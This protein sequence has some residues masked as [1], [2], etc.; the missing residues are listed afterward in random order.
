M[1]ELSVKVLGLIEEG[2]TINSICG[3]LNLSHKQL[4]NILRGL[5]MLGIEFNKKYYY[6]GETIYVPKKDLSWDTKKNTVNIIT[7]HD[8]NEFQ[9]MVISD[10]HVGN[11]LEAVDAWNKIYEYCIIN[12]IHIIIIAGDFLDG[13]NVGKHDH[14]KH[15]NSLEQIRYAVNNYPFDKN[16]INVVTLGNHDIDSLTS[17]GIDFSIYLRNFRP[18]IV[19]VGYGH[20]RIN[21]KNDRIFITHPLGINSNN[22][23]ELPSNYLLIKGHHHT[24]KSCISTNGN[25]S[26]TAPTLSNLFTSQD[27][28]L[29]GAIVLSIKFK[30][31][32]FDVVN[33]ENLMVN[34]RVN[35]VGET[36]F[37]ITPSKDRKYDGNIKHEEDFSKRK[38]LRKENK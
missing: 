10:L 13:I 2:F 23:F 34:D 32:F 6:D 17:Y 29:P 15:S 3:I 33:I 5:R 24:N 20:G 31:G 1:S 4:N 38:I 37:S 21:I 8:C 16:I 19:P 7:S 26:L 36:Q 27:I 35:V 30:N 22:G 14:K 9:A 12:N 18:D 28:F 11:Q 25:C